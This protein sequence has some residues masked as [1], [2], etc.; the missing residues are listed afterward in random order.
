MY[1]SVEDFK[2]V[3][4]AMEVFK[5]AHEMQLASLMQSINNFF[6]KLNIK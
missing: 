1:G 5:F 2:D 4:F 6:A 3:T